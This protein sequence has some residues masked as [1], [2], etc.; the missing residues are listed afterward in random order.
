MRTNNHDDNLGP[1]VASLNHSTRRKRICRVNVDISA[2]RYAI[3]RK[4]LR[5]RGFRLIK[6]STDPSIG[7]PTN[8]P[9]CDIWW[10]DRGD[11][12]HELPRLSP[13]Q[14]VNHFPSMEE[15]CRKDFLANNLYV[16]LV[17]VL[18]DAFVRFHVGDIGMR[19]I[20]YYPMNSSFFLVRSFFLQAVSIFVTLWIVDPNMK[21]T[22]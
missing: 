20:K 2:C 18:G 9:K 12:L 5:D 22:L 4:C 11:L 21:P 13:F 17:F 1:T 10:S 8:S 7:G 6:K 3:I 19:Y 15:I 16:G 14:K